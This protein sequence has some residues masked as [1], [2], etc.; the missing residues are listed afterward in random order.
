MVTHPSPWKVEAGGYLKF[1]S[2]H[3]LHSAFQDT[4][5]YRERDSESQGKTNII[6][7]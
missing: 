7:K 3:A 1:E 2:S 6:F 4:Q 5:N